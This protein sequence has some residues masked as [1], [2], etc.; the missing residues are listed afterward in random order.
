ME[1]QDIKFCVW[2]LHSKEKTK[3]KDDA[4]WDDKADRKEVKVCSPVI[5][6]LFIMAKMWKQ[7]KFL[8]VMNEQTKF[9]LPNLWNVTQPQR[10]GEALTPAT[11]WINLENMP[12]SARSHTQKAAYYMIPY[13]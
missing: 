9:R 10:R 2:N 7:P 3:S 1:K 6:A 12:L 11:M 4:K 5:A 13:I 8:P